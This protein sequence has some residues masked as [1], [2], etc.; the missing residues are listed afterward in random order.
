[1]WW[2]GT[3]HFCTTVTFARG[4]GLEPIVIAKKSKINKKN[5]SYFLPLQKFFVQKWPFIQKYPLVLK[6][7]WCKRVVVQRCSIVQ[8]WRRAKVSPRAKVSTRAK[9][10]PTLLSCTKY[11]FK[12]EYQKL[13]GKPWIT[14]ELSFQSKRKF[15]SLSLPSG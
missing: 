7:R 1:M 4:E 2:W 13:N 11:N 8:K 12:Y 14:R 15:W 3:G 6:W 9:M 5:N 10:T